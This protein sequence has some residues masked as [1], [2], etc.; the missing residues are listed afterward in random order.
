MTVKLLLEHNLKFLSLKGG[1]KG[2][3]ESTLAKM[4]H[5]LKSHVMAHLHNTVQTHS[6]THPASA[7]FNL[8]CPDVR[9][10][11]CAREKG[12]QLALTKT[13]MGGF[14]GREV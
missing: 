6:S 1:C 7:P 5:C 9:N 13:I 3:S 11:Y 4:P 12:P 2:S 14:R 8:K 10:V